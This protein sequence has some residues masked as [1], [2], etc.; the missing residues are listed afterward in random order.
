LTLTVAPVKWSANI[1]DNGKRAKGRKAHGN[2][3]LGDDA[4][5]LVRFQV[6]HEALVDLDLSD[7]QSLQPV[8]WR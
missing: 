6:A 2:R 7:G 5:G 8:S 3:G 4:I 1:A